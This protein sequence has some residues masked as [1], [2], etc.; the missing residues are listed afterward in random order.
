MSSAGNQT[1]EEVGIEDGDEIVI[2]G[3]QLE[4]EDT[5]VS[6]KPKSHEEK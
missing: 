1:L 4:E 2:G 5:K 3:I 6:A